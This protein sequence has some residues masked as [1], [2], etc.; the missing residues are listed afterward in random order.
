MLFRS[1]SMGA[2]IVF[3]G[4]LMMRQTAD[5][6]AAI[7]H[8]ALANAATIGLVTL[9]FFA[10][11]GETY[12]LSSTAAVLHDLDQGH[13]PIAWIGPYSGQLNF[14][15]RL[16][17]P[18]V[19]L[20]KAHPEQVAEWIAQHPEGRVVLYSRG[21]LATDP[22]LA[23]HRQRYHSG[24]LSVLPVSAPQLA[25]YIDRSAEDTQPGLGN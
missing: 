22:G 1:L 11:A 4:A 6:N 7:R 12:Q 18:V 15:A 25:Q 21:E 8:L 13:V 17:R 3:G 5:K 14:L 19:E 24:W 16:R 10:T 23:I 2:A 9:A 20:D